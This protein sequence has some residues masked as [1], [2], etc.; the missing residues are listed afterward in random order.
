MKFLL[1]IIIIMLSGCASM[2]PNPNVQFQPLSIYKNE[3]WQV[4]SD[5]SW[6]AIDN[7]DAFLWSQALDSE[8]FELRFDFIGKELLLVF[9]GDPMQG[10]WHQDT[11]IINIANHFLAIRKHTIYSADTFL[12][13]EPHSPIAGAAEEKSVHI[14]VDHRKLSIRVNGRYIGTFAIPYGADVGSTI[15]L[16]RYG[17]AGDIFL[18]DLQ[19]APR[20]D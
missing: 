7:R 14:V 4:V 3:H 13:Y 5:Q 17:G 8:S 16:A 10:G 12:R 15:A 18:S 19:Y 9:G 2:A 1:V 11:S 20:L 6:Q